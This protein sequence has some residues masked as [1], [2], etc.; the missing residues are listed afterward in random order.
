MGKVLPQRRSSDPVD[1]SVSTNEAA[2]FEEDASSNIGPVI[3]V[4]VNGKDG[5]RN[6]EDFTLRSQRT[7]HF[8]SLRI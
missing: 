3:L 5:M 2:A 7:R 1:P 4:I 8:Y 6:I